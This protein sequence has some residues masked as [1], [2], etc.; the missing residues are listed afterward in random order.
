MRFE[1][2][3][4]RNAKYDGFCLIKTCEVKQGSRGPYMD[5]TLADPDG[6][7]TAKIWDYNAETFGVYQPF[8]LVKVRGKYNTF[9]GQEQF[10][11]ERIRLTDETDNVK[12]SDFVACAPYDPAEMMQEVRDTVAAFT[13]PDLKLLVST[14]L[15]DNEKNL[16]FWPAAVRLHHAVNGGL[17]WHVTNI[18]KLAKGVVQVYPFVDTDLLYAGIILHDIEK[19]GEFEVTQVGLA[20]NYTPFGNL[21]GH[22]AGGA[23]YIAQVGASLGTDPEI[24]MLLEH[25]LIAHHGVPEFGSAIRPLFLEAELLSALD[26]LDANVY[27]FRENLK[28]MK[29]GDF[30]KKVWSLEDRK[31]YAHG[32]VNYSQE[33]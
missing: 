7:I 33:T 10:I 21:V 31:L 15:D 28:N 32:R 27:Q 16:L 3:D 17:L 14:I 1:C 11:V 29:A 13:N 25:M 30:T 23:I 6:E 4:N 26:T 2:C 18:L 9:N 19:L 12:L 20:T 22:L 24:L 8:D 5:M